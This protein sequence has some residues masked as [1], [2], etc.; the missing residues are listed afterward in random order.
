MPAAK[1]KGKERDSITDQ[2]AYDAAAL[3]AM[4]QDE[5]RKVVSLTGLKV[6]WWLSYTTK[7]KLNRCG[8]TAAAYSIDPAA[9]F[10]VERGPVARAVHRLGG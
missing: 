1:S 4:V 7:Y 9:A 3:H 10:Q 5:I 2:R 8:G 6:R